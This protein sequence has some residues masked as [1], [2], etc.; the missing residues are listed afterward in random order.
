VVPKQP[1][2]SLPEIRAAIQQRR[3]IR[4]EYARTGWTVEPH[5]LAQAAR[6]SLVIHAWVIDGPVKGEWMIF[7]YADMRH[8]RLLPE[9]FPARKR[10]PVLFDWR[11]PTTQPRRVRPMPAIHSAAP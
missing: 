3:S 4:F 11:G 5:E 6:C 7:R 10:P 1:Y 8:L 2:P 9:L